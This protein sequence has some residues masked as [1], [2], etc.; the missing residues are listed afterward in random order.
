MDRERLI[1]EF[2]QRKLDRHWNRWIDFWVELGFDYATPI[3]EQ[4]LPTG[5]EYLPTGPAYLHPV[6]I[7]KPSLEDLIIEKLIK[8]LDRLSGR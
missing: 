4:Y 5:P 3:G 1:N 2:L 7:P 6:L 8:K